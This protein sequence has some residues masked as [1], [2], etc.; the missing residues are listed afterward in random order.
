[1]ATKIWDYGIGIV[2]AIAYAIEFVIFT[3]FI[4]EEALQMANRM[5]INQ[6]GLSNKA[7][8]YGMLMIEH[9]YA[10]NQATQYFENVGPIALYG[11][12]AYST[13]FYA[14]KFTAEW[15]WIY[16]NGTRSQYSLYKMD[17]F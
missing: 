10:L 14:S 8:V 1:M 7:G 16:F 6:I 4:Y 12:N 2:E 11:C 15:G 13:Y 3:L 17:I 9:A 5:L